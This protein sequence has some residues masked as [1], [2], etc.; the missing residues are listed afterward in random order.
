MSD[1]LS[2][3]RAVA[4]PASDICDLYAFPSPR[5]AGRLVLVMTVFPRASAT[6]AFSDAMICRFRLRPVQIAATGIDARF[7]VGPADTE[8][9][10]DCTFD[11]TDDTG[12]QHSTCTTPDGIGLHVT[13]DDRAGVTDAGVSY[14]AGPASDPFIFQIESIMETITTGQ[15]AFGKYT[16][17]TMQDADVLAVVVEID[18]QRWLPGHQLWALVGETLAAGPRPVRLERVGR[19]EIKNI[20]L[21]W[22][23]NDP[24]NR[25][26]DVRD[27]YND[28]DAFAL[29][30]TYRNAFRERLSANLRFYDRL[31]HDIAWPADEHGVHPLTDLLLDDYLV[32]DV[33][34]PF[35]EDSWSEIEQSM[36]AGR[37]YTS[38][39]G[40]ALNDDF[41][42]TYY[43]WFINGG[44]GPRISDG[45]DQ[46]TV[47]AGTEFPYLAPPNSRRTA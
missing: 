26:I 30:E 35:A 42:D 12:T 25:D 1:H 22:N 8:V 34:K 19:P 40:R 31:D 38:C 47:P 10:F 3:P 5:Q 24:V 33:S 21:Q 46:A 6:A 39:G 41:L 15:M 36:L 45:V 29:R 11:S 9:V 2:S 37:P 14:F 20:G 16:T 32:V 7:D 23:G 44:N 28:E 43:T 18:C 13:V 27:V 4:D 17:N